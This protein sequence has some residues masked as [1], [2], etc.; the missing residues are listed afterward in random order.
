MADTELTLQRLAETLGSTGGKITL[1]DKD[2]VATV[3]PGKD[4]PVAHPRIPAGRYQ[5][6]M[7][8]GGSK[9]DA[10]YKSRFPA[11]YKGMIEITGVPGRSEVLLHTGNVASVKGDN[12]VWMPKDSEGCVLLGTTPPGALQS[13]GGWEIQ[14]GTSMQAF[15]QFYPLIYKLLGQGNVFLVVKDIG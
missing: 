12:G 13:A 15:A 10:R 7:K 2:I 1:G 4:Q 11:F 5:L 9:F 14:A 8:E 6:K 3:E